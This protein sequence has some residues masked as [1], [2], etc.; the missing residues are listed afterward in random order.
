[1]KNVIWALLLLGIFALDFV[2][3][4]YEISDAVRAKRDYAR[5]SEERE[6]E[7][8]RLFPIF[9]LDEKI[10]VKDCEQLARM[11]EKYFASASHLNAFER[12]NL[13]IARKNCETISILR[14]G[15]A[16]KKNF[17]NHIELTDFDKWSGD[18]IFAQNCGETDPDRATMEEKYGKF[19][20]KKL[21]EKKTVDYFTTN[22]R[23][24][25]IVKDLRDGRLY[26][27]REVA[28]GNFDRDDYMEALLEIAIAD[29][30]NNY[31][32]CYRLEKFSRKDGATL[33]RKV[34]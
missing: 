20:L 14:E 3:F 23:R 7:N 16:V 26:R 19:S 33:M 25:I 4:D 17:V 21:R 8:G 11:G 22:D 32:E 6:E 29:R 12:E 10:D 28:R 9:I 2:F 13:K 31:V 1:M 30:Q 27:V 5:T 24:A 34:W 18:V 15:R